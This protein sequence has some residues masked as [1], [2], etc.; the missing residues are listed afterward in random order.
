M[1]TIKAEIKKS[2]QKVDGTFNVKLRFTLDRKVKRISTSL[3]VSPTDLTRTGDFK[4]SS[5]VKEQIDNLVNEYKIKC[6]KLQ[7][8]LHHYTLEQIFQLLKYNSKETSEIEFISFCKNWISKATIK[9][10]SN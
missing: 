4:K 10:A 3:F 5:L 9:G 7:I 1:L 8:D 2:E 6:A